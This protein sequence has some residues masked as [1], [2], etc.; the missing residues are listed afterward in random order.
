MELTDDQKAALQEI[1]AFVKGDETIHVLSGYAGSGKSFLTK[2]IYYWAQ[3]NNISVAG[4]APT[5]K[6]RKVLESYLNQSSFVKVE[7]MTVAKFL[8]RMKQHGYIGSKNYKGSGSRAALFDLWLIDECSMIADRDV[9][10]IIKHI[11]KWKKK[12]LF[13]GDKAQIPNPSQKYDYNIDGTI[14]KKDS[15]SFDFPT[16]QLTTIIRQTNNPLLDIYTELRKDLFKETTIT[17]ENKVIE[18]KGVLFYEDEDK[19]LKKMKKMI[20]KSENIL[21]YRV[22]AY[23]NDSVRSYNKFIRE[24]LKYDTKFVIGDLLMGYNNVGWPTTIIENGQ[25]YIVTKITRT[26]THQIKFYKQSFLCS[27]LLLE[28]LVVDTDGHVSVFFPDITDN[29]AVLNK[30]KEVAKDVNKKGSTIK[31][32]K[33]YSHLKNQMLFMEN[34]YEYKGSV[35]SETQLK[36]TEPKL[37]HS[38]CYYIDNINGKLKIKNSKSVKK[39]LELYPT[40][41]NERIADNKPL[42]D[43]ERLIDRYQLIEKDIDYGYACTAHKAQGSTYH[44]VFIDE[45]DFGKIGNRWNSRYEAEE[46]GT[47]EKNQL[48]YVAYTRPTHMAVVLY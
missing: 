23:T 34:V 40:I 18:G 14:S 9:D 5:H 35:M 20:K 6:A 7:T 31:E 37:F 15:K 1:K 3:D 24:I 48:T 17:R 43:S 10:E 13:I 21:E 46:N 29:K 47:K 25:E 39:L 19:F 8:N 22:L 2:R 38:V 42:T 30:L 26:N 44:T 11:T 41:L 33:K 27:G 36:D 12:V 4:V 16:S 45:Y 32:F 28:L